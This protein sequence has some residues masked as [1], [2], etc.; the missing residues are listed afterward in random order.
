MRA[1]KLHHLY[2]CSITGKALACFSMSQTNEDRYHEKTLDNIEQAKMYIR[3]T[4]KDWLLSC[5]E[6]FILHKK[7]I[8]DNTNNATALNNV[9]ICLHT[10]NEFSGQSLEKICKRVLDGQQYYEGILP[11]PN[12]DS[13]TSSVE[14]LKE[15][16]SFCKNEVAQLKH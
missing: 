9:R 3:S 4:K 5:I 7:K 2:E 16:L 13:H 11:N 1:F 14:N 15:I 12:N 10:Y 6:K 8:W